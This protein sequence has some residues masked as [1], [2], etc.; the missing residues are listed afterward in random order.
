MAQ[1]ARDGDPLAAEVFRDAAEAV[2]TGVVNTV[3]IFNPEMVVIGG[4]VTHAGDLLFGPIE[5]MLGRYAMAVPRGAVRVVPAA[6]G[7]DAGLYG[8]LS[9]AASGEW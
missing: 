6:L 1:A 3:H 9:R 7:D 5:Q 8:A 2:G 4:G